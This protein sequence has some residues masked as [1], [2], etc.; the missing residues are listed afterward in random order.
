[1]RCYAMQMLGLF[2]CILLMNFNLQKI[3]TID[4]INMLLNYTSTPY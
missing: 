2:I 1:M 3:G 4:S